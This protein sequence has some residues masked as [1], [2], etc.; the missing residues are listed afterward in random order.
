MRDAYQLNDTQFGQPDNSPNPTVTDEGD[1][2]ACTATETCYKCQE[3]FQD[4]TNM[5]AQDV[6]SNLSWII[7][8][9]GGA[10]SSVTSAGAQ[11]LDINNMM[12]YPFYDPVPNMRY[13]Q[14]PASLPQTFVNPNMLSLSDGLRMRPKMEPYNICEGDDEAESS[15]RG[16]HD[17]CSWGGNSG[18]YQDAPSESPMI[19]LPSVHGGT[20]S[21]CI[22]GSFP[23]EQQPG[24][25]RF[26]YGQPD[27]SAGPIDP[28]QDGMWVY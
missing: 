12:K 24:G 21:S 22:T 19:H 27:V 5:T 10:N 14:D 7:R 16:Q 13:R 18:L 28:L 9:K 23:D 17:Y 1:C 8:S 25:Y 15:Q 3:Q 2:N 6:T 20:D 11:D 26:R 4:T